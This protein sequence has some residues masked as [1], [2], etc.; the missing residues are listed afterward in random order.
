ME[1]VI[2]PEE[3]SHCAAGVRWLRHLHGVATDSRRSEELFGAP[4]AWPAWL[5]EARLAPRVEDYFHALVRANFFG[6]LRGPFN[7]HAREQAS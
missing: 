1:G 2:Y 4:E 6:L 5:K 7:D 3:V